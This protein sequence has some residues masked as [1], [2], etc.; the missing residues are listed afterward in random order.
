MVSNLIIKRN[1]IEYRRKMLITRRKRFVFLG[2]YKEVDEEVT[3]IR[4]DKSRKRN[5]ITN[6]I[7]RK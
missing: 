4:K 7:Y 3:G 2:S 5:I 1:Q 6:K